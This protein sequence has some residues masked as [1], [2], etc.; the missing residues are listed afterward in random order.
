MRYDAT[1]SK[2]GHVEIE[3][4]MQARFPV[5][6]MCGGHLQRVYNVTPVH[7]NA[8]GF[9]ETDVR[10]F[11]K[12]VGKE[13]ATKFYAERDDIMRRAKAGRLTPYEKKLDALEAADAQR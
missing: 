10:Y 4:R 2:C 1:C 9:Y 5:R 11:E 3:K 13:R 6:H 12:Q 7:F 8:P